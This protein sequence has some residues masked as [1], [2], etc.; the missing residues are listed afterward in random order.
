[1]P[2]ARRTPKSAA[3]A[4]KDLDAAGVEFMLHGGLALDSVSITVAFFFP[5]R[6]RKFERGD[7]GAILDS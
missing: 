2:T 5:L 4:D 3:M 7:G 6:F 1:M